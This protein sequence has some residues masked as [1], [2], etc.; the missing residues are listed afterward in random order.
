MTNWICQ[1]AAATARS[2]GAK[3]CT[4]FSQHK[5]KVILRT[6]QYYIVLAIADQNLVLAL[7]PFQ[8]STTK[9]KEG[10]R[11]PMKGLSKEQQ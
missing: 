8:S 10:D 6:A 2:V 5:V 3:L 11:R 4:L 1:L 7:T 9:P